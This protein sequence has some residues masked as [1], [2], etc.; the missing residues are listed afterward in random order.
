MPKNTLDSIIEA[1]KLRDDVKAEAVA[2]KAAG[3]MDRYYACNRVLRAMW[4]ADRQQKGD[5]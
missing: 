4:E 3:E 2:A 5:D 1:Q